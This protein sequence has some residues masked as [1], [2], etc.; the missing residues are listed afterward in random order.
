MRRE[1]LIVPQTHPVLKAQLERPVIDIQRRAKPPHQEA[2]YRGDMSSG[3]LS[4]PASHL[5]TARHLLGA[6]NVVGVELD[7]L[8]KGGQRGLQL[9][10]PPLQQAW[11][12][13]AGADKRESKG[14]VGLPPTADKQAVLALADRQLLLH[15]L[16]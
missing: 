8:L 3:A 9:A 2:A 15:E 14:T 13:V 1:A 12:S 5:Q 6:L 7:Q 4:P 10:L 11:R 16:L